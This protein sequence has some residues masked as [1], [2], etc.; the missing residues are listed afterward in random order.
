MLIF[1][2]D[3]IKQCFPC[4]APPFW[5]QVI[6]AVTVL[7]LWHVIFIT[8][9]LNS[10]LM[11]SNYDLN[12][13]VYSCTSML[14]NCVI[15][16]L[17]FTWGW[18]W[19]VDNI[20]HIAS[21]HVHFA[22]TCTWSWSQSYGCDCTGTHRVLPEERCDVKE[23]M[24]FAFLCIHRRHHNNM[25]LLWMWSWRKYVSFGYGFISCMLLFL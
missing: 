22:F 20:Y 3:L 14:L 17:C 25:W 9:T 24:A 23:V 7:L 11:Y 16:L 15:L 13:V 21:C 2:N 19:S 5:R 1:L 6:V 12:M 18:S 10:E 4:V 8:Y